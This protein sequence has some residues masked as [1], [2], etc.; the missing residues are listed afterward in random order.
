MR[1]WWELVSDLLH[2]I[3]RLGKQLNRE[4]EGN[5]GMDG[6]RFLYETKKFV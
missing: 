1:M 6:I 3:G 4:L 5:G 2:I